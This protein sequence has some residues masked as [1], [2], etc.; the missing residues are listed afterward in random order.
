[1]KLLWISIVICLFFASCGEDKK[2]YKQP[3]PQTPAT[4]MLQSE[5]QA[6]EKAKDVERQV[7]KHAEML[8][9]KSEEP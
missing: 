6:L 8:K 4:P 2:P 5:R 3:V 7:N 1:M 9:Q